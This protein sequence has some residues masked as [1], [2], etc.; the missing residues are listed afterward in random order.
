MRYSGV[1]RYVT[2][3]RTYIRAHAYMHT[4]ARRYIHTR[5]RACTHTYTPSL[6]L[7]LPFLISYSAAPSPLP[8]ST[9]PLPLFLHT[10]F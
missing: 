3:T 7:L 10:L 9:S 5:V 1:V 2:R 6:T 4:H 8:P